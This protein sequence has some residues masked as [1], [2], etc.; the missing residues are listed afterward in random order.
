MILEIQ[1]ES[2]LRRKN[3]MGKAGVEPE[4]RYNV[5]CME[6]GSVWQPLAKSPLWWAAKQRAEKGF[7][8]AL[9]VSG[10]KCGCVKEERQPNAPFRVFGYDFD[11]R[12]FNIPFTTFMG[13]VKA[14]IE[15][16]KSGDVVFIQGVSSSVEQRLKMI[17]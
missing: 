8:D 9:H 3:H 12:D 10:K 16:N 4:V 5:H 14:F 15:A 11:C 13:P 7:L 1:K 2:S 17:F 6:C